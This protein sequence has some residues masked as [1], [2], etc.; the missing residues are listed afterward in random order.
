MKNF[1]RI[2]LFLP[3]L[4]AFG[5]CYSSQ[6]RNGESDLPSSSVLPAVSA[7]GNEL[8]RDKKFSGASFAV[9]K[10]GE[11]VHYS[12]H[13]VY[14]VDNPKPIAEDTLFRIYSM[15]KPIT[16]VAAMMLYEQGKFDLD[17]PVANY[18]PQFAAMRVLGDDG[19][20]RPAKNPITIRQLL[21]HSAG[22][23][24]GFAPDSPAD[25][26]YNEAQL[27]NLP[28]LDAFI[29]KLVSLP[30]RFE[31][32]TRYRY[33]VSIDVV[34]KLVE[35]LSGQDLNT[36][37]AQHVIVPLKM[38][39]TFFEVPADKLHR[40]ASDQYWNA[41]TNQIELVPVEY[42]RNFAEVGL[43]MG[44]GGLVSTLGDYVRFCQMILNRGE[45]EGSRILQPETVDLMLSDHLAPEVRSAGG[46]YPDINLY[47]GQSMGLGFAIIY[48]ETQ[49]PTEFAQ[50]EVS[51]GGLAGTQFWINPAAQ[52]AG[53]GMVQ[54][55]RQP[56]VFDALF[57]IAAQRGLNDLDA[58]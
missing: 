52:T 47:D 30:L 51:W 18:L 34:G 17:D 48:D 15:T 2:S 25:K 11:W 42:Q 39:D 46:P 45:L 44:G 43:Y 7:L 16:A 9:V 54:L 50:D 19:I 55:A 41:E 3:I 13:G 10:E 1:L 37:L 21:T 6:L 49:L 22:F 28:S 38:Q 36:Y 27:F 5:G 23:T 32:G 29:E 12:A 56:W 33:S 24:Y 31:P 20:E 4:F 58:Q 35:A 26:L 53:V 40:L 8:I 14:G 57:R